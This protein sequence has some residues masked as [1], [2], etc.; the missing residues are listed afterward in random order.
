MDIPA[1]IAAFSGV[2]SLSVA[3]YFGNKIESR[4]LRYLSAVFGLVVSITI[5]GYTPNLLGDT[6][7]K[8]ASTA[9]TYFAYII[10]AFAVIKGVLFR[11]KKECAE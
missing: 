9:G 5:M 1:I 7:T 8:T 6:S 4:I 10:V 11:K 3:V 2:I